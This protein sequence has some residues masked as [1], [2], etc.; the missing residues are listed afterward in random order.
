MNKVFARK[1]QIVDVDIKTKKRFLDK[2][3]IQKSGPGSITYGLLYDSQLVAVMTFI[4]Q[5]NK[6]FVLSRYAT[7]V[8]VPGGM[9]RLLTHFKRNHEWEKIETFSDNK[10]FDGHSYPLI[11]FSLEYELPPDYKYLVNGKLVHKFNFRL[12]KLAKILEGFD[13]NL[14]E[15]RNMELAGIPRIYDLGKKKWCMV[16]EKA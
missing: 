3:H 13:P 8:R 7:S 2:Y 12:A 5:P 4:A 9:S 14:S 6:V 11:G 16:N 15:K 10:D 1:C